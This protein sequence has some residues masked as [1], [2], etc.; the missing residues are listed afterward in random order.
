MWNVPTLS[1]AEKREMLAG[2][3]M[4]YIDPLTR[5]TWDPSSDFRLRDIP[6]EVLA[7]M[8]LWNR[9]PRAPPGR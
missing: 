3:S 7:G 5:A 8:R 4:R 1:S 6:D 2:D 9:Q